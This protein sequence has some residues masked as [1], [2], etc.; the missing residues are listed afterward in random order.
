MQAQLYN[1]GVNVECQCIENSN[2]SYNILYIAP[3]PG[4]YKLSIK[5]FGQ[6]IRG[7]PFSINVVTGARVTFRY[8]TL[9]LV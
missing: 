4:Q 3:E 9:Q 8:A 2:G 1:E 5:L 7:S 6:H